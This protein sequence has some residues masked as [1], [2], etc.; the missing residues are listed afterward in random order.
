MP[1]GTGTEHAQKQRSSWTPST[2]AH[3][4]EA[5]A[6]ELPVPRSAGMAPPAARSH[7]LSRTLLEA[8]LNP[9]LPGPRWAPWRGQEELNGEWAVSM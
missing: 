7:A 5:Q 6:S 9:A 4:W 3:A 2:T 1:C 8:F